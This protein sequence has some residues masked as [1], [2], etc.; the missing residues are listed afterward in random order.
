MLLHNK[1]LISVFLVVC[2]FV[3]T[4]CLSKKDDHYGEAITNH[5][6][7]ATKDILQNPADYDGKVVTVAGKIIRECP[8]GCWLDLEEDNGVIHVDMNP[9]GF[10]IPQKVGKTAMIQGEVK[11]K[12]NKPMIIGKGVEIR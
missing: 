5:D 8:T 3:A 11:V 6:H 10:A 12:N 2:V 7:T 1:I 4:G 9:S